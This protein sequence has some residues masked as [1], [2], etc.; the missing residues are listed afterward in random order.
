[1]MPRIL[2]SA[3]GWMRKVLQTIPVSSPAVHYG[4]LLAS[5]PHIIMEKCPSVFCVHCVYYSSENMEGVL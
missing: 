3:A 4:F 5:F 1:M 2:V